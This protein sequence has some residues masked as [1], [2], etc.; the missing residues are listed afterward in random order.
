MQITWPR[1]FPT[2]N[3][4]TSEWHH[5][6]DQK[7]EH[8]LSMMS[9]VTNRR[10]RERERG[11]RPPHGHDRTRREPWISR[12]PGLLNAAGRAKA[13]ESGHGRSLVRVLDGGQVTG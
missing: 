6:D 10:Q 7:S 3:E 9:E 11:V 5:G 13:A 12:D 4:R 1:R 8:P 2:P